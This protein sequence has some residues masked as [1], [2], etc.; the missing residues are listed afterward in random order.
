MFWKGTETDRKT[1]DEEKSAMVPW[2]DTK[3]FPN[4][5][6]EQTSRKY[7]KRR[8]HHIPHAKRPTDFVKKRN[9]RERKR[10]G[11]VNA[12]FGDLRDRVPFIK[13]DDKTSKLAVLR[14]A[15]QYIQFLYSLLVDN[16][17][18]SVKDVCSRMSSL[19]KQNDTME[20]EQC[21]STEDID[22]DENL[23]KMVSLI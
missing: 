18:S 2:M 9:Q 3:N 15:A 8:R 4:H 13:D 23:F 6:L 16:E 12:A 14:S 22:Q 7:P 17:S 20:P 1:L 19:S 10:V 5:Y 21:W 11:K